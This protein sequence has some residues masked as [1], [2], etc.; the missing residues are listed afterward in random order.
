M[1]GYGGDDKPFPAVG[2]LF[3]FSLHCAAHDNAAT[4]RAESLFNPLIAVNC[5]CCREIRSF[6]I[7]HQLIHGDV[8]VVDVGYDAV[9]HLRKVVGRHVGGHA[10]CDSGRAVHQQVGYFGRKHHRFLQRFV[11]VGLEVYRLLLYV[12]HHLLGNLLHAGFGVTHGGRAVTVYGS[13]VSLTVYQ[14]VAHN[15]ILGE[16]RHGVINGG[17]PVWM[18]LTQYFTHNSGRFFCRAVGKDTC[19]PHGVEDTPVHRLETVSHIR[20]GAGDNHRH[21][22]VNVGAFHLLVDVHRDDLSQ[23]HPFV[24]CHCLLFRMALLWQFIIRV[25]FHRN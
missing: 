6:D 25:V 5:A 1:V 12:N 13:E 17:V 19:V 14:R 8:A 23:R 11:E 16:T 21:G 7:L 24:I 4:A 18:V 2:V 15:P 9:H 3:V 20:Q 22:I 10:H